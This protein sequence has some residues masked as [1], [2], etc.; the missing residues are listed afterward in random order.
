MGCV[1]LFKT[2]SALAA[3]YGIAVT[4]TMAITTI[5]FYDVV[6]HRW[7]WPRSKAGALAGVFLIFDIAFFLANAA[8]F[9]DGGWFPLSIALFVF[10]IMTTWKR[11][12]RELANKFR[13]TM[14]PLEVFL[15]D[16]EQSKPLRVR[17]TA[18]FM[19]SSSVGTPPALLHHF[20]HSQSL[21]EQLVLLTVENVG[22]PEVSR[23]NRVSLVS[24]GNGVVH[25]TLRYGFMEVPDVPSALARSELRLNPATT[26]FYLGR[27][28]LLTNGPSKM[29]RWRKRLFAFIARNARPATSYFSLPANRVVE[30]GQQI[31][32]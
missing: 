16:I 30:L 23:D 24:K 17:G 19:A 21:H 12:R 1:V 20:K 4:G 7:N 6:T 27:E 10:T 3:A 13:D 11:G 14:L 5:V 18:V 28:T 26:S 9:F 31:D 32:L 22:V 25:V 15:D 8:K 29:A 2:S